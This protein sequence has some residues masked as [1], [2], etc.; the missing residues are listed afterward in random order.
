MR[1]FLIVL[2]VLLVSN[3]VTSQELNGNV[4][5]NAQL[6]GNA[7]AQIFKTLEKQLSEFLSNT[8]WTNKVFETQERIDCNMV[9]NINEFSG[10]SFTASIQV[11]SSR[12]V[13]GSSYSTPVYNINDKNFRFNYLEFQNIIY[14]ENQFES[15]LVSVIAFHVLILLGLDADTF[16]LNGGDIYYKQAQRIVNYTQQEPYAGWK[17]EDGLQSRFALVDNML[18]PAYKEFRTIVYDY[19]RKGMDV[20]SESTKEGKAA[21]ASS[22]NFFKVMNRSRPNSYLARIFFDAKADEIEQVFSGGPNVDVASLI[23]ILNRVAPTHS[24][25]WRNIKY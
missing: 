10:E 5:V 20:M 24:A 11:Q 23:E 4:V 2:T 19:H 25:K 6:T 8:K 7:N 16:E 18:S 9:I 1:K 3:L 15:N 17:L 21:V 22:L 14:N 12:P 13:Y